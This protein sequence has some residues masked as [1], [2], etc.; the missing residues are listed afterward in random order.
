M[1]ESEQ[2]SSNELAQMRTDL[3]TSRNL[4]AAVRTLMAW[5]RNLMGVFLFFSIMTKLF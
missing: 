4:M 5:V 1:T 3:P 2:L